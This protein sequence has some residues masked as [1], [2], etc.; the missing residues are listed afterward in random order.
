[1]RH[2][3]TNV[4]QAVI[5]GSGHWLMEEKPTETVA[6]IR[7]FLDASPE[8]RL[9]AGQYKFPDRGNPGTGSSGVLEFK[10]SF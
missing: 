7:G 6:L 1:M 4:Q 2:V 9:T 8:E 10:Q 5:M 3:A